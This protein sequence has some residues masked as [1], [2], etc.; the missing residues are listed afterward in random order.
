LRAHGVAESNFDAIL[1]RIAGGDK[2]SDTFDFLSSHPATSQRAHCP[3]NAE[4]K[5]SQN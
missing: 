5:S 4:K 2:D 3:K 1:C